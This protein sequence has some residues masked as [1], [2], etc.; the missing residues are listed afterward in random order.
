MN[1]R[2]PWIL[3]FVMASSLL[4]P[5]LA[6]VHAADSPFPDVKA[7]WQKAPVTKAVQR[8]YVNGYEDGTFRPD[9]HVT[10]AEFVKMIVSALR[11]QVS[12]QKGGEAWYT[13]YVNAAVKAGIHEWKDFT[14]GDWNTKMTRMEIARMAVRAA[15][16]ETEEESDGAYMYAATKYGL[17]HGMQDSQLAPDEPTTRAQSVTL[18]ER[19]LALKA[20]EN[21]PVDKYAVEQAE[22][23]W[24]GTNLQTKF[25]YIPT[26][27]PIVR[28]IGN[29]LTL[30]VHQFLIADM[31][32][33]KD[34]LA[35]MVR[36]FG[37][38]KTSQTPELDQSYVFNFKVSVKNEL[39][40]R[41]RTGG[42]FFYV[43]MPYREVFHDQFLYGFDTRKIGT[44]E[45]WMSFSR[46]KQSIDKMIASDR[47]PR[48]FLE[49]VGETVFLHE[50][51]YNMR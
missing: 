37:I 29:G 26:E 2:K 5:P 38:S 33:P 40:D 9:Q 4:L 28:K 23:F 6:A 32:D 25:G 22:I 30:T 46:D 13:P 36:G 41:S 34:P 20:G 18:I 35:K 12:P 48:F 1:N 11:L 16:L 27:F 15:S 49:I 7:E 47:K 14:K 51:P 17:I 24:K 21:M 44:Y 42:I 3:S 39:E 43:V 45:G 19:I 50:D 31:T 8:G 10:R